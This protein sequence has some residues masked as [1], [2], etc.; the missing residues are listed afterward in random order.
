MR[1]SLVLAFPY[2]ERRKRDAQECKLKTYLM[3]MPLNCRGF[4]DGF[5][6]DQLGLWAN[7][8]HGSMRL[9]FFM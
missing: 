9:I 4:T 7:A 6:K 5:I 8:L 2:Y 1:D 3:W